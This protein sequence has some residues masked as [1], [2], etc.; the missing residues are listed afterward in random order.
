GSVTKRPARRSPGG[1][2]SASSLKASAQG[3]AVR[4]EPPGGPSPAAWRDRPLGRA[5]S[6]ARRT[7]DPLSRRRA[8]LRAHTRRFQ[9][10]HLSPLSEDTT[11]PAGVVPFLSFS[12]PC[13]R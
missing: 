9:Y 10:H 4:E 3:R 1:P 13:P 5:P 11:A 6:S 8:S 2:R 7:G 12:I